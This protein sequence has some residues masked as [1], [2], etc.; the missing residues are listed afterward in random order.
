MAS[1][2][3]ITHLERTSAPFRMKKDTFFP[4]LE[5]CE[6]SALAT[7]VFPVSKT[8]IAKEGYLKG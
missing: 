4:N 5:A 1:C 7:N 6:A 8:S 3:R 2:E